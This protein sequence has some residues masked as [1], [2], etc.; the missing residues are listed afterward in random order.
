MSEQ[1]DIVD[2]VTDHVPT[3]EG[4][5]YPIVLP[6]SGSFPAATYLRASDFEDPTQDGPGMV[7]PTYRFQIWTETYIELDPIVREFRDAFNGRHDGP[8][9]SSLITATAPEQRDK[10]TGRYWRIVEVQGWQPALQAVGS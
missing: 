9:R 3:I 10:A 4:R 2:W 1:S 6:A 5:I 7:E 8:F